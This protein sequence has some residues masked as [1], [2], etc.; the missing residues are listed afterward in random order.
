VRV[1]QNFTETVEAIWASR[2]VGYRVPIFC[3][4]REITE[5]L[6]LTTLPVTLDFTTMK[7]PFEAAVFMVPKGSFTYQSEATDVVCVSYARAAMHLRTILHHKERYRY[8]VGPVGLT[9]NSSKKMAAACAFDHVLPFPYAAPYLRS[10]CRTKENSKRSV[11]SLQTVNLQ[12]N[13]TAHAKATSGA[14]AVRRSRTSPEPSES[15]EHRQ[16]LPPAGFDARRR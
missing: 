1:Y 8:G 3:V 9:R 5:A 10:S 13:P 4:G 15:N 2:L 7:L 14:N 12:P 6:K 11:P 16:Q